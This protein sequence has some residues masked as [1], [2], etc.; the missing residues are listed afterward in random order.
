MIKVCLILGDQLN[1]LI[2]LYFVFR[3]PKKW[4]KT[5][6]RKKMFESNFRDENKTVFSD[7]DLKVTLI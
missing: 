3:E 1:W 4:L 7:L 5:S 6:A 2:F